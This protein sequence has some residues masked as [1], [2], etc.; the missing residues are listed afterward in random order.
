MPEK[1]RTRCGFF[2]DH[3]FD[4]KITSMR[5]IFIGHGPSFKYQTRVS[6]FENI[7][8]YNVMCDLLGLKPAPNNG[9]HGSLNDILREP[10]FHPTMPEEV[11]PPMRAANSGVTVTQD[12]GCSCDDENRVEEI[13]EMFTPAPDG[14]YSY[15]RTHL[16][17]GRPAVMFG[18]RYSLL[19]HLEFISGYSK[20]LAMPLW[21]AYTLPRQEDPTSLPEVSANVNCIRIDP[22]VSPDYSQSCTAYQQNNHLTHGF[23]FPPELATSPNS[24]YEA[25]LITNTVPM[26]PAFKRIWNYLKVTLLRPYAEENN[27][28]NI[29]SGPI[30][31]NDHDSL[32]D[33]TEKIKAFSVDSPPVP[34]HFYTIVTSCQEVNQT[35]EECDGALKV[36]SFIIP[37]RP[38]NSEFCN[39]AEDDSQWVEDLLKLHTARVRDIEILT[40]L[41]LYRA[42]NLTYTSTLSLKT[43]LHT[44]EE[45]D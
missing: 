6:E 39:S 3:G 21:T 2:G 17:F 26:Y 33:T 16:P 29:L 43:Y 20:E 36:F 8:L 41:D 42:T 24:R 35:V 12:L 18:T 15:N 9:T 22:R 5:T 10:V 37:H 40:G 30:F 44:F 14:L 38:D 27:G 11:T 7:E 32:R 19:H 13:I 25:S 1:L 23:L 31:D 28:V 45:D 4:N 34:T